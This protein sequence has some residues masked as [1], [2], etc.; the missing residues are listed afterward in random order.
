M[1]K[2]EKFNYAM[3]HTKIVRFPKQ[4]LATFGDTIVQYYLISELM[5]KVNKVR[6]REGKVIAE[7]PKIVVPHYLLD[8]FEGWDEEVK[9]YARKAFEE[10]GEDIKGLGYKFKNNFEKENIISST[11]TDISDKIKAEIES[12]EENM[13]VIIE[14]VDDNWQVSLM[15]FIIELSMRSFPCNITELEER[16]F[17][18]RMS[19]D[20]KN[21]RIEIDQLFKDVRKDKSS[22]YKLGKKLRQ[23]G[24]FKEYEDKFF[25][26]FRNDT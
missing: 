3:K 4:S 18:N 1:N 14:G 26:L 10:Y 21:I 20:K 22:I 16:G 7:K 2:K 17:F 24:L 12:R 9:E 6:I 5:D 11:I 15:K 13:S 23:Y 25:A 19:G 8:V